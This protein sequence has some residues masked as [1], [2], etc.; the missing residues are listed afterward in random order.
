MDV[1]AYVSGSTGVRIR[2]RVCVYLRVYVDV[3]HVRIYECICVSVCTYVYMDMCTFM[4]LYPHS[5]VYV[6]V[7]I[8]VHA[9]IFECVYA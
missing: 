3:R 1:R 5:R 4:Y 6:H 7:Y 9:S 2:L 8:D